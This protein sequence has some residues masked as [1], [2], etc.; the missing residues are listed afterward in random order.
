MKKQFVT[1]EIALKL[2]ELNFDES[3]RFGNETSLYNNKGLHIFY[4]NY[5]V[6]MSGCDDGYIKAPLWQQAIDFIREKYGYVIYITEIGEN[7]SLYTYTIEIKDH[8]LY[9]I[10][11]LYSA[12]FGDLH[13]TYYQAREQAILYTLE[14]IKNK[15][16]NNQ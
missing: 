3:T 14:L 7:K 2:K 11:E 16:C 8:S 9:P 1:Y 6:M 12:Y 5:G 13:E 4:Y 15:Q 10:D